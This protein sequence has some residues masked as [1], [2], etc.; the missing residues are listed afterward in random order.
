[1][2]LN[3]DSKD[4]LD[5]ECFRTLQISFGMIYQTSLFRLTKIL[6]LMRKGQINIGP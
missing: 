3:D 4:D 6:V 5:N 2:F 1:M